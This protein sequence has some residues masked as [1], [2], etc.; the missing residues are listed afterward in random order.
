MGYLMQMNRRLLT[1][2]S[3]EAAGGHVEDLSASQLPSLGVAF[4]GEMM[5]DE[6]GLSRTV[7]NCSAA[8][9][10]AG[11][12]GLNSNP[13]PRP[14]FSSELESEGVFG[15]HH[16]RCLGSA[17]GWTAARLAAVYPL[18]VFP[19]ARLRR[20]NSPPLTWSPLSGRN[21]H[22]GAM[23]CVFRRFGFQRGAVEL[24]AGVLDYA[25]HRS[26]RRTS[27]MVQAAG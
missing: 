23:A 12:R 7:S 24:Y 5:K 20:G 25:I 9:C 1:H 21:M 11:G 6:G 4:N 13:S 15:E 10:P 27:P 3:S 26:V 18:P 22:T 8:Q 2:C 16:P 19:R 14:P 17:A